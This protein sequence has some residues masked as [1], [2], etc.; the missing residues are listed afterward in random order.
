MRWGAIVHITN[1][2]QIESVA[3]SHSNKK[4]TNISRYDI[5]FKKIWTVNRMAYDAGPRHYSF[6]SDIIDGAFPTWIRLAWASDALTFCTPRISSLSKH[7]K[8]C[9]VI[10]RFDAL[11]CVVFRWSNSEHPYETRLH[12]NRLQRWYSFLS[13]QCAASTQLFENLVHCSVT[14]WW[15]TIRMQKIEPFS[16]LRIGSPSGQIDDFNF[17][18]D[19]QQHRVK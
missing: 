14:E 19:S 8:M 4:S 1:L 17:L 7:A 10:Q 12:F 13:F 11:S 15:L 9:R 3:I 18:L 2:E 6:W 16:R 5:A